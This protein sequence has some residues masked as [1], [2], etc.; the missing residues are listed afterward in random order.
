MINKNFVPLLVIVLPERRLGN[1]SIST[2]PPQRAKRNYAPPSGTFPEDY[3]I[4]EVCEED[5]TDCESNYELYPIFSS[6]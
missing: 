5:D 2:L 3:R 6:V 1:A 4:M